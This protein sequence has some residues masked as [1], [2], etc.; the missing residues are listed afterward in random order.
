MFGKRFKHQYFN[1]YNLSPYPFYTSV[2]SDYRQNPLPFAPVPNAFTHQS[3]GV[4]GTSGY[5]ANYHPAMEVSPYFQGNYFQQSPYPFST[6][7]NSQSLFKNPLNFTEETYES[8]PTMMQNPYPYMNPYPKGSFLTKPPGMT[9]VLNSFK[10]QDGTLDISKMVDTAGQ[11]MNAVSQV[12]SV[13]KGISGM[14][15]V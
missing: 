11:M 12:S 8:N 4:L 5:T 15:K 1:E 9:S 13:V 3:W 10:S 2:Q 7:N 14:L 6:N